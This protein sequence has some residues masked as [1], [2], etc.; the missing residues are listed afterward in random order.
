[1]T[2]RHCVTYLD[3]T[4][5]LWDVEGDFSWGKGGSLFDSDADILRS[6]VGDDG[7]F[8]ATLPDEMLESARDSITR[9]LRYYETTPE[10][11]HRKVEDARHREII[12]QSA[13]LR[14]ADL[15]WDGDDLCR[16]LSP[17][18][19]ANLSPQI[20]DMGR[21]HVIVRINRPGSL[22]FNP[23]HRDGALSIWRNTVNLWIPI[24]GCDEK[25]RLPVAPGSHLTAE[26]ECLQTAARG[27]KI[28]GKTY[29]VPA[30][31]QTRAGDLRMMRPPVGYGE[32]LVFTPFLIHGAAVNFSQGTRISLELRLQVNGQR[33]GSVS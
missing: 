25:T 29:H 20:S 21:D 6:R 14:L 3:D 16:T 26:T 5:F 9:F 10:N 12:T 17:A 24:F 31:A 33:Y 18:V 23:P 1:M 15:G 30:I 7:F 2:I 4:P 32:A 11:Y 13:Q 19:G 27:A 8:I 22:D 28:G